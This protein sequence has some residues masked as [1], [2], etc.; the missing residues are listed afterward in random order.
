MRFAGQAV[1][2][3]AP[4]AANPD[5]SAPTGA[6]PPYT[7]TRG[8]SGMPAIRTNYT[9]PNASQIGLTDMPSMAFPQF[10]FPNMSNPDFNARVRV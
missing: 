7:A 10:Q 3:R 2:Y 9:A 5:Y 8:D 6:E 4:R 1:R